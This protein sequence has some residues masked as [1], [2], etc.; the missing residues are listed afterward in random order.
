[1]FPNIKKQAAQKPEKK[2]RRWDKRLAAHYGIP[3]HARQYAKRYGSSVEHMLSEWL[4]RGEIKH[5][6]MPD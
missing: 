4:Q 1:M 5:R 3:K 2:Q 6:P